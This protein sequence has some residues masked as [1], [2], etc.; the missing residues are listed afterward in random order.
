MLNIWKFLADIVFR[1]VIIGIPVLGYI[2]EKECGA[3]LMF[4]LGCFISSLLIGVY[5]RNYNEIK[6]D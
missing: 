1:L 4:G 6:V 2:L 3:T 5:G